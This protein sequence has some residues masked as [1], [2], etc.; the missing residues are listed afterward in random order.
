MSTL[1]FGRAMSDEP[2]ESIDQL[3]ELF[4]ASAKSPAQRRVG[5]E[6]E[7]LALR[8]DGSSLPYEA[9]AGPSIR[10][11]LERLGALARM[12]PVLEEDRLIGLEGAAGTVSLE[13]GGQIEFSSVPAATLHELAHLVDAHSKRLRRAGSELGVR[14][15]V[16]GYQPFTPL[17][18]AEWM[19]K[20]RY[21]I[22][23]EYLP[24]RGRLAHRM[25]SQTASIQCSFDFENEEDWRRKFRAAHVLTPLVQAIFCNSPF[26]DGRPNGFL[27]Y[28]TRVWE[29]TDPARCGFL[30]A[31]FGDEPSMEDYV[32]YA[33]DVPMMFLIRG[34]R[35]LAMRGYSFRRFFEKGYE[36]SFP[37]TEDWG[38]HLSGIFTQ[39][40]LKSYIE[41]RAHDLVPAPLAMAVPALWKGILYDRGALE[42]ALALMGRPTHSQAMSLMAQVA[43]RGLRAEHRGR[44]LLALARELADISAEG[45]HR[46]RRRRKDGR[47]ESMY[48]QALQELLGRGL[49]PAD[50]LLRRFR[51][52][53]KG[54][55]L[56]S[57]E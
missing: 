37:T 7:D 25:M 53:W 20:A 32:Q 38:L 24:A 46:Q 52:E 35:W 28:R 56:A 12:S 49:T 51:R 40:R 30:P 13:P 6:I 42:A 34:G 47:D 16:Q 50:D 22:M 18:G 31:A 17:K 15:A 2:I 36:G 19:P 3:V 43:R 9:P 11:L 55:L 26:R 48:L 8:P 5:I 21:R 45:L 27:S 14:W 29:Q 44:P 1:A 23:R 41:V 54:N 4:R 57:L 39:V 33:L 10:A